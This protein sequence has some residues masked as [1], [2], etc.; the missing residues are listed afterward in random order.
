M[1]PLRQAIHRVR[2]H[3]AETLPIRRDVLPEQKSICL[4]NAHSDDSGLTIQRHGP[5]VGSA[6]CADLRY[7]L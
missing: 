2:F 7:G 6:R 1:H 4:K 5:Q 3:F